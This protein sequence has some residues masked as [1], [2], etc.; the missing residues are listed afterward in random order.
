MWLVQL[1]METSFY[2]KKLQHKDIPWLCPC[3]VWWPS[4]SFEGWMHY[5]NRSGTLMIRFIGTVEQLHAWWTRLNTFP[6][7]PKPGLWQSKSQLDETFHKFAESG[8]NVTTSGRPYLSGVIG[9]GEYVEEYLCFKVRAWSSSIN[10]LN[11]IAKSQPQA[12]FSTL[13][14]G[15]LSK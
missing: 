7:Y 3:M 14:H 11:D 12:A 13:T 15:L 10:I 1:L 5:V 8:V 9:S 6:I 4:H 2:L